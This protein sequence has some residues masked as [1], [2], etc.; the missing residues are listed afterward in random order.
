MAQNYYSKDRKRIGILLII[1]LFIG[2]NQLSAQTETKI[3]EIECYN[4]GDG[5]YYCH[6]TKNK[7]PLQGKMRIIDGYT[8]QY[9]DAVFDKGIPHGSWKT[10]RYNTLIRE[11]MYKEGVFHGEN[12]E[13]YSDGSVKWVSPFVNGKTEGKF[14]EYGSNGKVE[15]EIYF[16]NGLKDGTEITY[17]TD[18]NLRSEATYSEGKETGRKWQR[19]SDYELT[20]HYREGKYHGEYSAIYTNGNVKEKGSYIDG[21]KDGTWEIGRKDG[22][23]VRS[24]VYAD[25]DKIQETIYFTSG[26]IEAVRELKNGRK[27]GWE[28]TYDSRS[29]NL[30]SEL[31]YKDGQV[32]SDTG[33]TGTGNALGLVRQTKQMSENGSPYIATFY[34]VNGKYEDEYTE[35][36][37]D[38]D[39]G[40]K[41]RGQ[42]QNGKKTGLWVYENRFGGKTQEESYLNDKL[43]G[44]QTFYDGGGNVSKYYTYKEGIR[45]GEYAEYNYKTIR[46]KGN[47]INGEIAGLQV[48]YYENGNPYTEE[49]RPRN[50]SEARTHKMFYEDGTLE[51]ESRTEG[52]RDVEEK[53]YHKNGK[54]K[55]LFKINDSGRLELI[56]SYDET[57]KRTK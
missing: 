28:R 48:T 25:N 19:Y 44:R 27:N 52:G 1:I 38:D 31:F 33:V 37:V 7:K 56:E 50:P 8:S 26:T 18:G 9:T 39:K 53:Q 20:A 49:Y 3:S 2:L 10:Y 41:T 17:D 51:R 47:Y 11:Y 36:W 29:G 24:E 35:Q 15:S 34:Q 23:K 46:R 45:D 22:T 42:Y 54:L 4:L 30:K 55:N 32:S 12:K 13:F 14:I 16:K 43:D 6:Y 21:K 40:M 5:R 57:G